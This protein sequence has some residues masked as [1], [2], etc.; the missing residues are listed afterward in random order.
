MKELS[1]NA[2]E[3]QEKYLQIIGS[4]IV[5]GHILKKSF[6]SP[7]DYWTDGGVNEAPKPLSDNGKR[8]KEVSVPVVLRE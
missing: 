8:R 6:V 1:S 7:S 2:A 5:R 3:R 4:T